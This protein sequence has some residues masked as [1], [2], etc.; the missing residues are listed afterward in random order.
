MADSPPT[1]PDKKRQAP[2]PI[3]FLKPGEE[4]PAP[5]PEQRPAA[6]WVT[7]P[8]D[9]Q[10][11]QYPQAPA[12]PRPPSGPGANRARVAGILLIVASGASVV[13]LLIAAFP[14]LTPQQYANYTNDTGLYLLSQ[15]CSLFLVWG[16]AIMVVG[17]IM[18][19]Q[20]LNWRMTVGC[21]FFSMLLL[22][23]YAVLVLD[24]I[25]LGASFL[26]IVGFVL[27][28]M[29]RQDFRS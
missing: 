2:P 20:R 7:R 26:G 8:E 17:G 14:P 28:V 24:P 1:T 9:Y 19:F 22:G 13:S 4:Q 16:Q 29:S 10:R 6:A 11:P 15:V 27:T 23:G 25:M 12:P 21:A 5:P 18:A 3:E